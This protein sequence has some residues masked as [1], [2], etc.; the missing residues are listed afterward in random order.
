MR[1]TFRL[2][3]T[4]SLLLLLALAGCGSEAGGK[5]DGSARAE[6]KSSAA[7][8]AKAPAKKPAPADLGKA[9]DAELSAVVESAGFKDL[10]VLRKV[11]DDYEKVSIFVKEP[12]MALVLYDFN[13]VLV[14]K[15]DFTPLLDLNDQRALRV[16]AMQ[17]VGSIALMGA[18]LEVLQKG[19]CVDL[20]TC[21]KALSGA[22]YGEINEL[23]GRVQLGP[24]GYQLVNAKK[25]AEYVRTQVYDFKPEKPDTVHFVKGT[26]FVAAMPDGDKPA[27]KDALEKLLGTLR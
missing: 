24:V 13:K 26:V 3:T 19:G 11:D 17:G 2:G 5:S 6:G 8:S 7:A 14:R 20:D 4:S 18:T 23:G 22:G 27:P 1:T 16:S 10:T 12:A 9:T 15:T 21:K 25:G